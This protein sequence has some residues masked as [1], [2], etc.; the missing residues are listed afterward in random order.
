[1]GDGCPDLHAAKWIAAA[2]AVV[3][4]ALGVLEARF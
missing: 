1:M 4:Y 3:G 2:R